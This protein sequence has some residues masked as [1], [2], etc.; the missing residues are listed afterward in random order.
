MADAEFTCPECR[1]T[2]LYYETRKGLDPRVKRCRVICQ[3]CKIK[4]TKRSKEKK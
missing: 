4:F 3:S 1:E 2:G